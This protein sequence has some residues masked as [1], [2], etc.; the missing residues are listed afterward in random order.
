MANPSF[1][2][3]TL[4]GKLDHVIEECAEVILAAQ[5]YKRFG[6]HAKLVYLD[7]EQGPMSVEYDNKTDLLNEIADTVAAMQRFVISLVE[8][9]SMT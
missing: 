2:P 7:P 1:F 3:D 4:E 9:P 6:P 8:S 5:K